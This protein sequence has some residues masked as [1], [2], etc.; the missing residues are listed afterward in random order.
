M[1]DYYC[2]HCGAD[3]EEQYGFDPDGKYPERIHFI[4]MF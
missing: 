2:T 3:L 1:G 4:V